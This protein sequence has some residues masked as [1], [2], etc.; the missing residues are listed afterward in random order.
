MKSK[1]Y[2]V[3]VVG[4]TGLV[5]QE[6]L[7]VLKE[8]DFPTSRVRVFASESSAGE[9]LDYG[10]ETL[11]VEALK[12]GSLSKDPSDFVLFATSAELSEKFVPEAARAGSVAIDNSS[13][14]RMQSDVPLVVPEVNPEALE[15]A[16]ETRIIANPNCSTI[17]LVVCLKAFVPYGLKRVVVSTYQ[18]VSGAGSDAMT[19][20]E[21]QIS[22]LF[23]HG[24]ATKK[25]F[26]H[27]IAFNCI[28]HIDSFLPSGFTKEEM[29]MINESRKI[30]GLSDLKIT[31]TAVR[32]PTFNC[33][34]ESVNVEL[35]QDISIDELRAQLT[36]CG[37]IV[38]DDPSKNLYPLG[39]GLA[40][41][42]EVFVGRIRRDES[43]AHGYHLWIVADNLRKGAATNAVQIAE[44]WIK[45]GLPLAL[46]A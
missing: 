37:A 44:E 46:A 24:E 22:S 9:G 40:G 23:S 5:G 25:V 4:A 45:R 41:R 14:F 13:F 39:F 12:E 27:Q 6:M 11:V 42:D 17:Q 35:S 18:S 3:S 32:V 33:H 31:A 30:L 15:Q 1:Q 7:R 29:K 16:E 10:D 26:P 34:A 36:E 20:L 2:S 19:E 38:F 28:P 43:V 8:R 21:N